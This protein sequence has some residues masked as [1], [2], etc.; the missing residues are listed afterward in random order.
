MVNNMTGLKKHQAFEHGVLD[1]ERH[2]RLVSDLDNVALTA[3]IFGYPE[4]VWMPL[5]DTCGAAE[6]TWIEHHKNVQDG[7]YTGK[8][9]FGGVYTGQVKDPDVMVRMMALAGC[10]VRNFV[11]ARVIT[12]QV[13]MERLDQGDEPDASVALI[14]NFFDVQKGGKSPLL[15]WKISQLQGWL[16]HRFQRGLGTVLYVSN[17]SL[18]GNLWGTDMRDHIG[19]HLIEIKV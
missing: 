15:D 11:D 3:G 9:T 4:F 1:E 13:L 19:K 10:F 16:L 17:M 2:A 14:P 7:N 12:R 6:I 5:S 8:R 18:L